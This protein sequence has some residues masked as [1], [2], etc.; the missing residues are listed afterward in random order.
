MT[1]MVCF[2]S[3][4]AK[5]CVPV[6][7]TRAVRTAEGMVALPAALQDVTGVVPGD[8]PLSVL[9]VLGAGGGHILVI[10]S[11][12]NRF[13]LLVDEVNGLCRV[14][15][16]QIRPAPRGQDRTLV[17]GT[18]DLGDGLTLVVDPAAMAARL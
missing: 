6:E 3:A 9:T 8:P 5:Y 16:A 7:D 11:D 4:G 2:S 14:D 1:T 10:E 15:E 17:S 13:G 12:G 18:L